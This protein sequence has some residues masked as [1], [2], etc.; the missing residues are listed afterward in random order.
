LRTGSDR[1]PVVEAQKSGRRDRCQ[2]GLRTGRSRQGVELRKDHC[3]VAVGGKEGV[4]AQAWAGEWPEEEGHSR[5]LE[6]ALG[7]PVLRK[8]RRLA[9]EEVW[10]PFETRA[11]PKDGDFEGTR[12]DAVPGRLR[13]GVEADKV[14]AGAGSVKERV[15]RDEERVLAGEYRVPHER[16]REREKNR[17]REGWTCLKEQGSC[18]KTTS[19]NQEDWNPTTQ[20]SPLPCHEHE[21]QCPFHRKCLHAGTW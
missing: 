3:R 11:E 16:V 2:T 7:G 20:E 9:P 8:H 10:A 18:R 21:D 19:S 6:G 5:S 17:K 14:G 13:I 15:R 12:W 4:V 1:S